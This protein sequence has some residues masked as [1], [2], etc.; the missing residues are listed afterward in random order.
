[1]LNL[2]D[3]LVP[4]DP[5]RRVPEEP[6]DKTG[7]RTPAAKVPGFGRA[8]LESNMK[9]TPLDLRQTNFRTA[10]R[11]FEKTEVLA[12]L[13]EVADDYEQAL[14]ETDRLQGEVKRLEA[15]LNEHRESERNLRNTLLTAQRLADGI[16]SSAEEEANRIVREAETRSELVLQKAQGRSEDIQREIDGLRMK[17]REV[18]MSVEATIAAL[19][20]ALDFI[21]DQDQRDRDD[22]ILLHRPRQIEPIADARAAIGDTLPPAKAE[23]R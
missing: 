2:R 15:L 3:P 1:M 22:K 16:K 17:R 21:R 11:G 14:R 18:E 9:V 7:R 10:M 23:G 20:N 6:I 19:K 8:G 13:A 12:F 5:S 4:P